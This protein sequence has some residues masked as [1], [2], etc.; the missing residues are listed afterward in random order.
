MYILLTFQEFL[1]GVGLLLGQNHPCEGGK[2][3]GCVVDRLELLL[4]FFIK[5]KVKVFFKLFGEFNS[6]SMTTIFLIN[7]H[8]LYFEL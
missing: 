7:S 8:G 2:V 5:N 6:K 3:R 1:D 4:A